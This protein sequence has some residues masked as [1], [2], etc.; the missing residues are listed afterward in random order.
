MYMFKMLMLFHKATMII[1]TFSK[2]MTLRLRFRQIKKNPQNSREVRVFRV[3]LS[4]KL[5]EW[6]YIHL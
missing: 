3:G 2:H 1:I 6:E 5:N 4:L